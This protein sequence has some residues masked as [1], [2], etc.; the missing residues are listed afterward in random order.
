MKE[1]QKIESKTY[2]LFNE[3]NRQLKK[4]E[5]AES[6]YLRAKHFRYVKNYSNQVTQC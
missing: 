6:G 5:R 2:Q 3:T 1:M 4:V